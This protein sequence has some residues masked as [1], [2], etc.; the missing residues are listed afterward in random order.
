M[1]DHGTGHLLGNLQ[2]C[3]Y[4]R[5]R[6]GSRWSRPGGNIPKTVK[7]ERCNAHRWGG[8]LGQAVAR[9]SVIAS[10][11]S[12]KTGNRPPTIRLYC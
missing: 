9:L 7:E 4:L 6:D 5:D 12:F 1:H 8:G 3:D 11:A 2:D 10:H